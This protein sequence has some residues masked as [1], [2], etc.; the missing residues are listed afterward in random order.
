[1]MAILAISEGWKVVKHLAF[2]GAQEGH[3][4][5]HEAGDDQQQRGHTAVEGGGEGGEEDHQR[6]AKA[7]EAQLSEEDAHT[8]SVVVVGP[9][10]AGREDHDH[11][12]G[13]YE[14]GQEEKG[15]VKG[16][17]LYPAALRP[18]VPEFASGVPGVFRVFGRRLTTRAAA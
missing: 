14:K 3:Q 4:G 13:Q 12:D 16:A 15:K 11:A 5:Q 7:G 9:G 18:S 8:V 2:S 1:M 10:E 6:D 17:A